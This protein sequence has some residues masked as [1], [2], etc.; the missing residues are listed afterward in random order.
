[1]NKINHKKT[2]CIL[3]DY[4]LYSTGLIEAGTNVFEDIDWKE[5][6]AKHIQGIVKKKKKSWIGQ[7]TI[8]DLFK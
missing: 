6:R 1:M 4:I 8:L 7:S 2:L 3:L 5:Q